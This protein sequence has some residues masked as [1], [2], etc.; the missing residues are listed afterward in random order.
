MSILPTVKEKKEERL[1]D[2]DGVKHWVVSGWKDETWHRR[3]DRE[4]R[5]D[6]FLNGRLDSQSQT[7]SKLDKEK[8]E[9]IWTE[10]IWYWKGGRMQI[11]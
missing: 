10:V 1:D 3:K 5:P 11:R 7:Q 8:L 4:T 6:F 9:I 2:E